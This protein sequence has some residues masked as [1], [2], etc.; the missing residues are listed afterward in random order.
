MCHLMKLG[1]PNRFYST[2]LDISGNRSRGQIAAEVACLGIC[3]M[4]SRTAHSGG[5]Q[6]VPGIAVFGGFLSRGLLPAAAVARA[7]R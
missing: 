7:V 6:A 3:C 1:E 2:A 5:Y 4:R